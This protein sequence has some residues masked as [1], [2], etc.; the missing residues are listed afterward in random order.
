LAT[1]PCVSTT[2]EA[3][4][5]CAS[6]V[7]ARHDISRHSSLLHKPPTPPRPDYGHPGGAAALVPVTGN[8]VA[9]PQK[10]KRGG[11]QKQEEQQGP[12][13]TVERPH[14][15]VQSGHEFCVYITSILVSK[16]GHTHFLCGAHDQGTGGSLKPILH[17][18]QKEKKRSSQDTKTDMGWLGKGNGVQTDLDLGNLL[19][20]IGFF[21]VFLFALSFLLLLH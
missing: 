12:S 6:F 8:R 15:M 14:I 17:G 11:G 19:A 21:C 2:A 13:L 10:L 7:N 4:R 9:L 20:C 3:G 16:F 5:A 18:K 1:P